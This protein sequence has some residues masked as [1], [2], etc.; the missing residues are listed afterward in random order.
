MTRQTDLDRL[1]H[2][3]GYEDMGIGFARKSALG[4]AK[5]IMREHGPGAIRGI[6]R[7]M[8]EPQT[9]DVLSC[10]DYDPDLDGPG[11][12]LD[13]AKGMVNGCIIGLIMWAGIIW[14]LYEWLK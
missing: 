14:A 7:E 13:A 11:H 4:T 8:E 6:I 10:E 5:G 12:D 3:T 9:Q 1:W 2:D